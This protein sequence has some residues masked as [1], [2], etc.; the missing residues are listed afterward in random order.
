MKEAKVK[1]SEQPQSDGDPS[2]QAAAVNKGWRWEQKW[3]GYGQNTSPCEGERLCRASK[4]SM[5]VKQESKT[6]KDYM[7][8]HINLFTFIMIHII[9]AKIR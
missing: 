5:T 3:E 8:T 4:S 9:V 1:L 2:D 6:K 7:L